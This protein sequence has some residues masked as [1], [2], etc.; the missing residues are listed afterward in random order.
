MVEIMIATCHA[1][2]SDFLTEADAYVVRPTPNGV[3]LYCYCQIKGFDEVTA[4]E[5]LSIR[6]SFKLFLADLKASKDS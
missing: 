6:E 5:K 3:L 2:K 4:P 1:C